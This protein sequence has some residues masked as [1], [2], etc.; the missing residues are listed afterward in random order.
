MGHRRALAAIAL[1]TCLLTGAAVPA[2]AASAHVM[3]VWAMNE[4]AG[5]TWMTD[6]GGRGHHGQIGREVGTGLAT[7]YESGYRFERLEPDT[8]PARPGH[9]VSVADHSDL[10]PGERDFAVTMRL[11]TTHKFG[12]IIQKGQATVT[13]GSWK[14]QIPNGRATCTYRGS[15]GTI[16]LIAPYKINDGV[17]HVVRCVR[18]RQ[19]VFLSIDGRQAAVR[20][21]WTG[22]IDNQ[23]PVSIGG[24]LDCDQVEVGCDYYAGDLDWVTVE[25]A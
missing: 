20:E 23:W 4:T 18:L 1:L 13:G 5:S 22:T 10:D 17:W 25:A 8:P 9:V 3:A 24:K 19:G 7:G 14:V 12:N 2:H 21:G 11:R 15:K 6:A 16:E